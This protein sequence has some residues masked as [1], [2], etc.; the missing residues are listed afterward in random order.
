MCENY[1]GHSLLFTRSIELNGWQMAG[2][3]TYSPDDTFPFL[4]GTVA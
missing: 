2:L 1:I 4:S 3:L